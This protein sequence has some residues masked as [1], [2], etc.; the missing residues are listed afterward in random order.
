[1][2]SSDV[3]KYQD[4]QSQN[5]DSCK[6]TD[7]RRN[8]RIDQPNEDTIIESDEEY[9]RPERAENGGFLSRI[10][11]FFLL[12][13]HEFTSNPMP[14]LPVQLRSHQANDINDPKATRASSFASSEETICSSSCSSDDESFNYST[15]KKKK[16]SVQDAYIYTFRS[17]TNIIVHF[18]MELKMLV[19]HARF[20]SFAILFQLVH[21]IFTN[22]A[23]YYHTKLSAAQRVPL[24]DVGFAVLPKLKG[25]WW[26]VSEYIFLVILII[27]SGLSVSILFIRW[28]SPI[29]KPL[30]AV[31][32]LRRICMNLVACQTLRI[33]SFLVTTLPGASRQCLYN[34]PDNLTSKEMIQGSADPSGNPRG[35]LPPTSVYEILFRIDATNGCGDLM[36]SSHT[37]FSMTFVC[38]LFKYYNWVRLKRF[39]FALQVIIVPFIIAARKHYSVDVFT[40]LYVTPLVFETLD[41]RFPDL[42]SSVELKKNYK[43]S[44]QVASEGE[45]SFIAVVEVFKKLFYLNLNDVPNDIIDSITN[46]SPKNCESPGM[47]DFKGKSIRFDDRGLMKRSI[48][49]QEGKRSPNCV[50]DIV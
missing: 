44:F 5:V 7:R 1:M 47:E 9:I 17:R 41:R 34:V 23:Y 20:I 12:G 29:G 27:P 2:I 36:F 11:S 30:Y 31:Q 46:H 33:I 21:N 4:E 13:P 19:T 6:K 28:R 26:M 42:D 16:L 24:A 48:S 8:R 43:I 40:A 45:N 50:A 25:E 37:I 3:R 32:V 14:H 35:W 39:M 18:L 38:I 10:Y 15:P 49:A 22:I